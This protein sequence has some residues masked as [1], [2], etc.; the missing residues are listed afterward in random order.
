MRVISNGHVV[1]FGIP[2]EPDPGPKFPFFGNIQAI[3]YAPN[4][5]FLF[6]I[7]GDI[8]TGTT[9]R[10]VLLNESRTVVLTTRSVDLDIERQPIAAGQVWWDA[11]I[12]LGLGI[13]S[14]IYGVAANPD[15]AA[16]AALSVVFPTL[17]LDN[18]TWHGVG[19]AC[20]VDME[21]PLDS[22]ECYVLN[23]D[24]LNMVPFCSSNGAVDPR[25]K[26][27]V[28]SWI[29]ILSRFETA[30]IVKNKYDDWQL[31]VCLR[32]QDRPNIQISSMLR[33]N[34][35]YEQPEVQIAATE[36]LNLLGYIAN[37]FAQE[38]LA[39]REPDDELRFPLEIQVAG[40][41]YWLSREISIGVGSQ[42][43]LIREYNNRYDKN[44]V[45]L[46]SGKRSENPGICAI[47]RI[48]YISRRD[49]IHIAKLL[50]RGALISG[51]VTHFEQGDWT[52][53]IRVALTLDDRPKL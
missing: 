51:S 5:E 48:G 22:S 21:E 4:D 49:A 37:R 33:L 53:D 14:R 34:D 40:A 36:C 8:Y 7:N 44:A 2:K 31:R 13:V 9:F 28:T 30:H 42:V 45:L 18:L 32:Y 25:P 46:T 20:K 39:A 38:N 24:D 3:D 23:S 26:K 52:I 10:V 27:P 6:P 16:S 41:E 11:A 50:D 12:H 17:Q 47:Q 1:S 35:Y 29:A 19:S 43:N 15:A